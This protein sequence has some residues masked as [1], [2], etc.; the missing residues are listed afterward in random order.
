MLRLRAGHEDCLAA[1]SRSMGPQQRNNDDH[2]CPQMHGRVL[3][4]TPHPMTSEGIFDGHRIHPAIV[5][6][7]SL[8]S[9]FLTMHTGEDQ[10]EFEGSITPVCNISFKISSS[11]CRAERGGRRGGCRIGSAS[12]VSI[13]CSKTLQY[14]R[15]IGPVAN[16]SL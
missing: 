16:A 4:L 12:P 10:G 6:A 15:S 13:S 8:P 11:A 14:P 2:N 1:N 7:V 9:F 5:D 3:L